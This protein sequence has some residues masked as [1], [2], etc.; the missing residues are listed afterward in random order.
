MIQELVDEIDC[1]V[2]KIHSTEADTYI[3]FS[4]LISKIQMKYEE[5]VRI[6][7]SLNEIG[8]DISIEGVVSQLNEL[9]SAVK[10]FDKVRIYDCLEYNIKDTLLFYNE[11][12]KIMNE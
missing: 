12:L 7:P 2:K 3:Q 5:F 8:M 1:I 4:E 9:Y 6:I 11:I 10:V